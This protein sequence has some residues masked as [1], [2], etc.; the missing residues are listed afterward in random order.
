VW[1]HFSG[2]DLVD[3]AAFRGHTMLDRYVEEDFRQKLIDRPDEVA[4]AMNA[5]HA[6]RREEILAEAMPP[7]PW[8]EIDLMR[9]LRLGELRARL[10]LTW[11]A[12]PDHDFD[13]FER[14]A[15]KAIRSADAAGVGL[16][17][18]ILPSIDQIPSEGGSAPEVVETMRR[19]RSAGA[20]VFDLTSAFRDAGVDAVFAQGARGG[21]LS[22]YGNE[23]VARF[24]E[25]QIAPAL[26]GREGNDRELSK[27]LGPASR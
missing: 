1:F 14:I 2:N 8:E 4:D 22:P 6:E 3:M 27:A 16:A 20:P 9:A 12:A 10:G 15:R 24:F 26:R 11:T 23:V 13:Y 5:A 18:V 25:E 21:H 7:D 19:L 17:F